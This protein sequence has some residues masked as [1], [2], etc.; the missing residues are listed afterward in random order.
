MESRGGVIPLWMMDQRWSQRTHISVDTIRSCLIERIFLAS[1][2][3]NKY[4]F[5]TVMLAEES[6]LR[7][8][9]KPSPFSKPQCWNVR[10]RDVNTPEVGDAL[11]LLEPYVRTQWIIPEFRHN[12]ARTQRRQLCSTRRST[13]GAPRNFPWYSQLCSRTSRSASGCASTKIP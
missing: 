11:E 3:G 7:P 4:P 8:S 1:S 9:W 5:L 13:A 12:C 6:L 2:P 10:K